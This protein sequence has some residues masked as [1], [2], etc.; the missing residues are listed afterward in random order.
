VGH[1]GADYY[2]A[3]PAR[4]VPVTVLP[5]WTGGAAA[6]LGLE[7]AIDAAAFRSLLAGR[8][9]SDLGG[10]RH[11]AGRPPRIGGYDLTF[12]APKSVSVVFALGGEEVART[13][14]EQHRAA[15]D[16]AV[17]YLEA[18]AVTA[19]RRSGGDRAVIPTTGMA[20][21]VFTHAVSRTLDPHLHSHVV[22]GNLVHGVDGRW[23]ACDQRGLM[24]HR[25][26]A[27]AVYDAH[28]RRDMTSALGVEWTEGA[29]S[30]DAVGHGGLQRFE[31]AGVPTTLLGTFSMRRAD[32][33][34]HLD[35]VGTQ[36]ARANRIAWAVTRPAKDVSDGAGY[37][38]LNQEWARRADLVDRMD[39]EEV[40]GRT[41]P[42][43]DRLPVLD[44]HRYGAVIS[45][46]P[47]GG[48]RRRDVVEAFGSGSRGGVDA[49]D[50]G[51]LVAEWVPASEAVGVAEPLHAR[52]A[53]MPGGHVVRALGPRPLEPDAHAVW[54]GA[55]R[56]I[57][58]YRFRWGATKSPELLGVAESMSVSG[59]A[60]LPTLRLADHVRTMRHIAAARTRLGRA[61]PPTVELGLGRDR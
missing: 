50:L 12:S 47:H 25:A 4:E 28:L 53:V 42:S 17:A 55:A 16:G 45:L 60:A 38:T 13:V 29:G 36:S 31:V 54:A 61:E 34:Q 37:A 40:L 8:L 43:K 7:G 5:W 52:G 57:E 21:G 24:A 6:G 9:G 48:A 20:A 39:L 41:P 49:A 26:A 59:L 10:T 27:S 51:R 30:S 11:A 18:H 58:A 22:M 23:S 19:D 14:I 46:T 2:L 15:V 3:D 33:R 32:I 56:E 1:D 44:E 35:S